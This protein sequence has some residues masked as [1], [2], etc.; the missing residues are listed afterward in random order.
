MT[1][2]YETGEVKITPSQLMSRREVSTLDRY[3]RCQMNLAK[4]LFVVYFVNSSLNSGSEFYTPS[5]S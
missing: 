2:N 3:V 4:V 1:K 5:I